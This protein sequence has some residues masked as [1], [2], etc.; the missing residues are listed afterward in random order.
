MRG[1]GDLEAAVMD[2]LWAWEQPASVREVLADLRKDR[3]FAYTTVMTVLDNLHRKGFVTRE[4]DGRAYRYSPA[5]SRQEYSAELMR[6]ALEQSGDHTTTLLRFV[7]K[8]TSEEADAV[9]KALRGRRG[10]SGRR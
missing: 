5:S 4:L 3:D 1:F 6:Q 10:G 8:M 9:R 2:R 7:G